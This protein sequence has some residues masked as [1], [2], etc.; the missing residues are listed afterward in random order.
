MSFKKRQYPKASRK[1][2]FNLLPITGCLVVLSLAFLAEF[3]NQ[4]Q[5]FCMDQKPI[6]LWLSN[7][8]PLLDPISV[9]LR[10]DGKE[11]F[12]T[13]SLSLHFNRDSGI[14]LQPG[15]HTISCS[16]VGG[17]YQITDTLL[18]KKYTVGYQIQI[19]YYHNPSLEEYEAWR[20]KKHTQNLL[21][22]NR[23][24]DPQKASI[25]GKL[26]EQQPD[27]HQEP[28]HYRPHPPTFTI[29]SQELGAGYQVDCLE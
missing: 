28:I 3:L 7:H 14:M 2:S 19:N 27:V 17:L 22:T 26:I 4:E 20:I 25:L 12:R 21:N 10:I 24:S 9:K 11:V 1:R 23:W 15:K 29:S 8:S 16:T 5:G 6:N 18:V 13:D